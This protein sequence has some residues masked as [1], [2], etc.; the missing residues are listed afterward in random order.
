MLE[1]RA[2]VRDK[3]AKKSKVYIAQVYVPP[4]LRLAVI[5]A[6]LAPSPDGAVFVHRLRDGDVHGCK[7]FSEKRF[8]L[9]G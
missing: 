1:E 6:Y 7:L 8:R 3:H 2:E 5:L 4:S 9:H